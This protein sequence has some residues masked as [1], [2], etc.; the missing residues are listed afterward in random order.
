MA[1]RIYIGPAEKKEDVLELPAAASILPGVIAVRS[2]GQAAAAGAAL[3]ADVEF[4]VVDANVLGEI[5]EAY[6]T[7]DTVQLLRPTSGEYY[8][9]RLAAS[10]TIAAG[11]GLTT[12]SS[13]L[14]VAESTNHALFIADEAVTTGSGVTS[15]IRVRRQ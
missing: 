8:Y 13:G 11:N 12:N 9:V 6:A 14:L 1:N 3:A 7:G 5:T 2:S 15:F 10:Q 4:F